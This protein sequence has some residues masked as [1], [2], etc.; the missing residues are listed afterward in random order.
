MLKCASARDAVWWV[1]FV[2]ELTNNNEIASRTGNIR[3]PL[4]GKRQEI[5]ILWSTPTR[6]R[7]DDVH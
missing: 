1:R 2:V 5:V 7:V 3:R 4:E 6:K